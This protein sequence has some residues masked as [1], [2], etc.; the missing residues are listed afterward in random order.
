M[1]ALRRIV[2]PLALLCLVWL[3]SALMP[4]AAHAAPC[5][6]PCTKAQITTDIGTN[7][8]DNTIGAITPALLRSTVLEAIGSY[9]DANG[10]T[11]LS[12]AA[13]NWVS[14]IPTLSSITC[15]QPAIA[16]VSGW[17]TGVATA[18][19]VAANTAGGPAVPSGALTLDGV[20]YGGGSG[21]SPGSTAAGTNGQLFLG[22]TSGAPQWGTMSGD[23]T[24]TNAGALTVAAGAITDAK[25]ANMNAWTV[26][27][28]N[29]SG[30][31]APTDFTIDG[32][33]LKA[34]PASGDEIWIWDVSG[35]AWK[36]T[37][38]SALSTVGSVASLNGQTGAVN[39]VAGTGINVA[40]S[41]G[42]VTV[43]NAGRV[44]LA[45]NATYFVRTVPVA[46]TISNASP[47]VVTHTAHGY[48][49][50]QLVTFNSTTSLPTG[51]TAGTIYCVL[52]AGLA[53]NTY[54]VGATC[55][56]SA[57]NTSSAGSGTFTEQAGNDLTGTGSAQTATAA[58]M[59]LQG[60][61]NYLQQNIDVGNF[62][63]TIQA[64][65]SGG[66][67]VALY[68]T[69]FANM[70]FV[71]GNA[72]VNTPAVDIKGDT[73]T[74]TNCVIS[75]LAVGGSAFA[76]EQ[77]TQI[78]IEGF[79]IT[80]ATNSGY[81]L[82]SDTGATLWWGNMAFGPMTGTGNTAHINAHT[83]GARAICLANYSIIGA[84]AIHWYGERGGYIECPSVTITITGTPAFAGAFAFA[85]NSGLVYANGNT[86]T[87]SATGTRY[88]AQ[89]LGNINTNSGSTTFFP[90][91]AAGTPSAI[92]T[93][94]ASGASC[95]G[96]Y[97]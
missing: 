71:G 29:T 59:T 82:L 24:I 63:A 58:F 34:S 7:W 56:G 23:A 6:A 75:D 76:A 65:C 5:T 57:I 26:S 68:G 17:G 93:F 81:G 42:N 92:H 87:G 94:T 60:G 77:G 72:V 4:Q 74:P 48:L 28:N 83:T 39:V 47:G 13:H 45:A 27:G 31:T 70:P 9:I 25:R 33:T 15:T 90:G 91:N 97:N 30:A 88:F 35:S 66:G 80:S 21:A 50:G 14:A 54:E 43:T 10:G 8:P 52:A 46:V 78:K 62:N 96:L 1:I 19:G 3:F 16:D 11:S 69:T 32:L 18:L 38:A 73:T 53:T 89:N 36:K 84:A 41:G 55:G 67:G 86:F 20:V 22:V 12:C 37:T 85:D 2:A 40:A 61:I 44:L 79:E 95:C 51:L 49:A 64:A